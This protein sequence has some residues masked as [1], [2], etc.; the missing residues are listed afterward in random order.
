YHTVDGSAVGGT[1]FTPASGTVSWG[2]GDLSDKTIAIALTNHGATQN[3][4]FSVQLSAPDGSL[5]NAGWPTTANV[6]L[7]A[8][9]PA[10]SSLPEGF[11]T[12]GTWVVAN[13]TAF[14]GTTSLGSP[15]A[16]S[17]SWYLNYEGNFSAGTVAFAYRTSL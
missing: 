5:V 3:K 9:W 17:A 7:A 15:S 8:P 12:I 4:V 2:D 1:D 14:E 13:D 11:S 16:V 6:L 10:S